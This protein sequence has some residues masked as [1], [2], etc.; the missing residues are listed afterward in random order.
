M[1]FP[2]IGENGADVFQTLDRA[3]GGRAKYQK[4]DLS[5]SIECTGYSQPRGSK[6]DERTRYSTAGD[7]EG[8]DPIT[9]QIPAEAHCD[10]SETGS[11]TD[12]IQDSDHSVLG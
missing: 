3:F 7:I 9:A 10:S 2:I 12:Q 11:V 4:T 1:T 6:A 5:G 8:C